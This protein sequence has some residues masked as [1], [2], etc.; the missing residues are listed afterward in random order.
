[1]AEALSD[2]AYRLI[3]KKLVASE[4]VAGQKISEQTIASECGISRTPVREAIRR[5]TEEGL[6]YQIPSSG[7]Y[8]A[9]LDRYQLSD[10]YEV[11]MAIECFAIDR[12]TRNLTKDNR[13]ELRRLCDEMHAIIVKLRSQKQQVLDGPPLVAF[14]TADLTF[15]LLLLKAAGNRL[16]L[17]IVTNAYQRNHFFGHHSHRRDLHHLAWVWR[18]HAKIE[19]ALRRSDAESARGW[20]RAHITR[21]L[22]DALAAFD[23]AAAHVADAGRDPVDDALAQL[24]TRLA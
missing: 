11:R 3:T 13:Q 16:A 22:A 23:K 24:T 1:M 12:A 5:L 17:K 2:I 14:L 15:H 6:L 7:T 4:L 20:M 8:V 21:S 10:A 18:H 9:S 19:R